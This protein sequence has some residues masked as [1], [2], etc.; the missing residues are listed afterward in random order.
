MERTM[1]YWPPHYGEA[2]QG[3]HE[4]QSDQ[5]RESAATYAGLGP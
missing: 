2:R 3:R 5:S 4:T 1:S